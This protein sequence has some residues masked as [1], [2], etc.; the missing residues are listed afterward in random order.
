[1]S[2]HHLTKEQ[3]IE[4]V[5]DSRDSVASA[6]KLL[7][8]VANN[9]SRMA[10]FS[11]S[12]LNDLNTLLEGDHSLL[13]LIT[14]L[15]DVR[16]ASVDRELSAMSDRQAELAKFRIQEENGVKAAKPA[17][18][19]ELGK[20]YTEWKE[21]GMSRKE[22]AASVGVNYNH[23]NAKFRQVIGEGGEGKIE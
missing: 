6:G 15:Y 9:M 8:E 12:T 13:K 11:P 23:L 19:E 2:K 20:R 17:N 22:Y 5:R 16:N 7:I 14:T 3:F 10:D 18:K 4:I 1:M 21:S